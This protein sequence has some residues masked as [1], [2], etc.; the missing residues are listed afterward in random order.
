MS[1]VVLVNDWFDSSMY[2]AKSQYGKTK[3][4]EG[5]R[6]KEKGRDGEREPKPFKLILGRDGM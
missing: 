6:N 3:E 1:I 5:E 2:H 4:K